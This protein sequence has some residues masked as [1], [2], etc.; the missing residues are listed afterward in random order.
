MSPAGAQT[1]PSAEESFLARWLNV[2]G[3]TVAIRHRDA[4][5][6]AGVV[7]ANQLQ[8][9]ETLRG[10]LKFDQRGRYAL[11][12]GL[13]TGPR[14]SGGWDNTGWGINDAQK[15]LAVRALYVAA[16]PVEG[17]DAEAGGLYIARGES[18]EI[19]SYDE[20]GYITGERLRI[21]RPAELFFDEI[22]ATNAYFTASI[23]HVAVSKRLRHIDESNYQQFLLAKRVGKRVAVSADYTIETGRRTWREA[24]RL[25]IRE[26]RVIDSVILENY[27]RTNASAASGFA[28][29][30]EK[31]VTKRLDV[32]GGYARIDP[33]YGALNSDRFTIGRRVYGMA[34]YALPKDLAASV[35]ITNAVGR[36]GALPQRRLSIV[37]LTYNALPALRRAGL[38]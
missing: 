24:M 23:E 36:Q 31:A 8:H 19:T 11:T 17:V 13:F 5:S 6:S 7:T 18:T 37:S 10:R 26:A 14:F 20:D 22:S 32:N 9:R 25:N 29:T 1:P 12:F 33:A 30:M 2:Q 28:V 34:T 27:Q 4:T 35:F 38:R 3:A 21:R 16:R 15:N